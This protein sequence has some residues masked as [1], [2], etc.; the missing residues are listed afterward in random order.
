LVNDKRDSKS[1]DDND[2]DD[3]DDDAYRLFR[4]LLFLFSLLLIDDW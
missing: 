1:I 2:D 3:D 4:S